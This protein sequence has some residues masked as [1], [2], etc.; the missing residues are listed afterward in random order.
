MKEVGHVSS[1]LS[2]FRSLVSRIGD[3]GA[4]ALIHHFRKGLPSRILDQFPSHHSRIDSAQDLMDITLELDSRY[5][6]R[7]EKI[8]HSEKKA[9]ASKS[10]SSHPKD[11]SSSIQKKEEFLEDGHAPFF[12]V[13]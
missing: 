10:N 2:D 8:H 12:F 13:Q 5:H 6:E 11:S 7:Q 3:W 1:Y 9:E 4:R